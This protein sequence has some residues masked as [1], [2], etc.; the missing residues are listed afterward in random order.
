VSDGGLDLARF[1]GALAP[2]GVKIG[3]RRIGLG[4]ETAFIDP[5]RAPTQA[6]LARR[7]ASGAAR[8]VARRLLGELGS[9]ASAVLPRKPSGAPDWPEGVLGSLAHDDL[10]AAAAVARAGS[11][12]ALGLDIEPAEPL[13]AE[14]LALALS[15]A[16][17]RSV[18]GV[19][20]M[21]RL[22]FS[23][24]EAVYKAIHPWDGSP[25]EYEDIEVNLARGEA[26][27]RDGR[28]V[29]VVVEFGSRLLV[30]AVVTK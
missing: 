9:D 11:P 20:V 18:E 29:Q 26:A 21:A 7:R 30:A 5:G 16:E 22:I 27:L 3:A 4:D 28:F 8:I 25:L 14:V 6:N 24:K 12:R 19:P 2:H 15:D 1:R 17:R 10:F 23:A 13:P